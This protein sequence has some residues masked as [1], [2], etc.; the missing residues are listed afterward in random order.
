LQV[1]AEGIEDE[2]AWQLLSEAGCDLGQGFFLRRPG[3]GAQVG[4]WLRERELEQRSF[5]R[6]EDEIELRVLPLDPPA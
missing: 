6:L 1:T 4:R 2:R 5:A 3:T